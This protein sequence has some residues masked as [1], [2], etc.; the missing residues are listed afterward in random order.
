[1]PS[2]NSDQDSSRRHRLNTSG[3]STFSS[4]CLFF[5]LLCF[6]ALRS[7]PAISRARLLT[8]RP[9]GSV[10]CVQCAQHIFVWLIIHFWRRGGENMMISEG[11]CESWINFPK[12]RQP[13]TFFPCWGYA[14]PADSGIGCPLSPPTDWGSWWKKAYCPRALQPPRHGR[15]PKD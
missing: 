14:V 4:F 15:M 8:R 11:G 9:H 12:S 3:F 10:V 5:L 13:N 2:K 6:E 7:I 1:M